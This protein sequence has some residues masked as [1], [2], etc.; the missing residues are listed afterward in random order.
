MTWKTDE[1]SGGIMCSFLREPKVSVTYKEQPE[2]ICTYWIEGYD[3]SVFRR[4]IPKSYGIK[5]ARWITRGKRLGEKLSSAP[6]R[7]FPFGGGEGYVW[8]HH[9]RDGKYDVDL[10]VALFSCGD[11]DYLVVLHGLYP[12]ERAHDKPD[13]F[14]NMISS[15]EC[16][17]E[18]DN[19]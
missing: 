8:E 13:L 17:L 14:N 3:S 9:I 12:P 4:F 7:A 10:R 16:D 18:Q 6:K 15:A 1:Y 11:M 2:H 5:I 19:N